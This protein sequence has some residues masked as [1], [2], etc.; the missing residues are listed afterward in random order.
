MSVRSYI[1]LDPLF[2]DHKAAYPDGAGFALVLTWCFAAQQHRPGHFRNR[3][4]L[5]V[6]LEKRAK[7]VP[8]LIDHGDIIERPD[9]TLYVEGWDEWQ[10]GDWQV[11][12]RM[13]R[14]RSR[15]GSNGAD[16]N[17]TSNIVTVPSV[18]TPSDVSVSVSVSDDVSV[19]V[20]TV[21]QPLRGNRGGDAA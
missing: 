20:P 17:T 1:R 5:A 9:G 19:S 4:L 2:P 7:W 21:I 8:F 11:I 15:K 16:R 10:E 18:Y 13:R 14:V 3:R 6:F 12:E